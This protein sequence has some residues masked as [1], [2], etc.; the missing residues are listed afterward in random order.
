MAQ[1]QP[2]VWGGGGQQLTYEQT[3]KRREVADALAAKGETPQTFGAGLNRIGEALLAKSY[4]DQASAS[5]TAG[6]E[7]RKSVIEALLA[8]S[9]PTMADIGGALGNDWVANDAGSSAVVQALLGQE[10]QQNDPLRQQQ[11]Q[12]GEI[13]LAN[14]EK[15]PAPDYGF[16][17]LPDG[18]IVRTDSTSGG[19]ENMG[20]FG[21]PEPGFSMVTPEEAAAAGLPPTGAYQKG[22]DGK[23][24]EIGGGG[25]TINNMGNI[26]AGYSVE[27]DEQGRPV[28]MAPVPGSPAALEADAAAAKTDMR[29]NQATITSDTVLNE[30]GKARGLISGWSTGPGQWVLGNLPFT[31]AAE[32]N[33]HVSSLKAIASSENI[34]MMRQSS[35]TGAA[36]GNTSDADLKLLQDKAGALDPQSSN[37]PEMLDDY[38]RTL[39]RIVHGPE[40]GDAIFAQT[41]GAAPGAA[42]PIGEPPEGLSPEEWQFLTPEE[43]A[44][45]QN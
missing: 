42:A 43:R 37:F 40:V 20:Q 17:E 35:P 44:L 30:A 9:D 45:W 8:N 32:L 2:F 29:E 4:G 38:E 12:M 1:T 11:L 28:T 15:P 25:T 41:R 33:R 14:A 18:S 22:P 5:E 39:L 3:K 13:E 7:S 19:V 31:Q 21:T 36:M 16:M 6:A 27:Y 10:L 24:Y 26:P 34:N 23:I